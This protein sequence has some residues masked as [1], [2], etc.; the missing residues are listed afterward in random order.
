MSLSERFHGLT[1]FSIRRTPAREVFLLIR[2]MARHNELEG[3]KKIG[4]NRVIRRPAGDN[5]F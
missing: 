1:P 2:R 4:P 5:W 3:E